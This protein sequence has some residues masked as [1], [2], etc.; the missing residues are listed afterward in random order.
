[1]TLLWI[2][3]SVCS[4]SC[5]HH[6][7]L[8]TVETE[9]SS[10]DVIEISFVGK[11]ESPSPFF[12]PSWKQ[13]YVIFV[14]LPLSWPLRCFPWCCLKMGC[15][16]HMRIVLWEN[17]CCRMMMMMNSVTLCIEC[18][19]CLEFKK[20]LHWLKI[21]VTSTL[22]SQQLDSKLKWK[23]FGPV[24]GNKTGAGV[25]TCN[26]KVRNLAS[27]KEI[28]SHFLL[29]HYLILGS[30]LGVSNPRD[31]HRVFHLFNC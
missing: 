18:F 22:C 16:Y 5:K 19:I 20:S 10:E 24:R 31:W 29:P 11:Y 13:F 8:L 21:L 2:N 23:K 30:G 14:F 7:N 25:A 15:T 27:K 12:S 4:K 3:S 1:M 6:L 28:A 26:R 17:V 9:E